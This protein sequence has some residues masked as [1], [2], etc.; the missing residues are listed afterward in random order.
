[1]EKYHTKGS[2]SGLEYNVIPPRLLN[3]ANFGVPR[4]RERVFFVGFRSGLGVEW[5]F[6]EARREAPAAGA[7][8]SATT[9]CPAAQ[10]PGRART[11]SP[12]R[13]LATTRKS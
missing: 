11:V 8:D 1:L 6:P 9:H 3:A 4:R 5:S 2:W 7:A 12:S 13:P 10:Y